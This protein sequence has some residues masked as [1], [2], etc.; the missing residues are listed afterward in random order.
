MVNTIFSLQIW[1]F[2]GSNMKSVSS[3]K[4]FE[5]HHISVGQKLAM[6]K[7]RSTS[8]VTF[9]SLRTLETAPDEAMQL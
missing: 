5:V 3:E 6:L 9:F 2:F 4:F 8:A 7:I 1:A